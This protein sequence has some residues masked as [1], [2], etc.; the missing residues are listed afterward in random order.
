LRTATLAKPGTVY[1]SLHTA[2]PGEATSGTEVSGGSYA[3]APVGVA[4]ANWT[5]G[6]SGTASTVAN[7]AQIVFP[8]PTADWGVVGWWGMFDAASGGNM[9]FYGALGAA[10]TILSDDN[11]PSFAAGAFVISC[12]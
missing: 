5:E 1:L 8:R 7:A 10:R 4:D 3:R 6:T 9:L 2:A 11:P 12:D